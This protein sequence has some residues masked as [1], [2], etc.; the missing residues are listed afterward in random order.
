MLIVTTVIFYIVDWVEIVIIFRLEE[1]GKNDV[2]AHGN[3]G[4]TR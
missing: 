1:D 4:F 2:L 3:G